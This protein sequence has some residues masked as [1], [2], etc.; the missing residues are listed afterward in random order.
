MERCLHYFRLLPGTE[1]KFDRMHAEVEPEVAADMAA[2]GLHDVTVF[3]R[4]TDA[5]RYALAEPDR[6]TAYRRYLEQPST[7]ARRRH[8]R[9]IVAELEA[10]GGGLIWFDEVFHTDAPDPGGPWARG[11]FTMVIDVEHAEL[12]DRLH[13]EPWPE[14]IEAIAEAGYRDYTGFRRGA[15]VVYY[16]RYYPDFQTVIDRI[17]ATDVAARWGAA[18]GD[19][20]TTFTDEDGRN[21]SA[22]EV[23]HVD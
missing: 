11:F 2:A 20:I 9:G 16:G 6:E 8:L 10:P 14:M 18:L 12:Y 4:G 19:A 15:H 21:F 23:Y 1:T 3:R 5:W 22:T 17:N 13:A 7:Q